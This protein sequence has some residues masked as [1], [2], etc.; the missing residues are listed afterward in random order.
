M[1]LFYTCLQS[2]L[3]LHTA[4]F[5]VVITLW[6]NPL[7]KTYFLLRLITCNVLTWYFRLGWLRH[8]HELYQLW[9]T[10]TYLSKS[11]TSSCRIFPRQSKTSSSDRRLVVVGCP[12]FRVLWICDIKRRARYWPL[13]RADITL[14]CYLPL[15]TMFETWAKQETMLAN[16]I[17]GLL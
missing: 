5:F 3:P 6:K 1:W 2:V 14:L 4:C 15:R 16:Q 10:W 8:L 17:C 11:K 13:P 12:G 7:T 9:K